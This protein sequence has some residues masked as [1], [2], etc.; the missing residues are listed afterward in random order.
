MINNILIMNGYGL[1]VWSAFAFTLVSFASLYFITKTQYI[2]ERN[3]FIVKFGT[4][5]SERVSLAKSQGMNKEILSN[6]SS[7]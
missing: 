2:K 5:N 6:T 1:Y 7:I 4:L 3:K